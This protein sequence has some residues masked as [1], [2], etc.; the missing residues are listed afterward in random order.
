[1]KVEISVIHKGKLSADAYWYT[2]SVQYT[3]FSRQREHNH[4]SQAAVYLG[5]KA[6]RGNRVVECWKWCEC[7]FDVGV[8]WFIMRHVKERF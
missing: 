1:V 5:Q 2:W 6:C 7:K 4:R 8:L 3:L